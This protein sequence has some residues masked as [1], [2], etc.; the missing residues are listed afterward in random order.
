MWSGSTL[1]RFGSGTRGQVR[2]LYE[3]VVSLCLQRM[4]QP[5]T[6]VCVSDLNSI[7]E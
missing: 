3:G 4:E 1:R 7:S 2:A 6:V 5:L